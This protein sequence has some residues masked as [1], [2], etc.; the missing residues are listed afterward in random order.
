MTEVTFHLPHPIESHRLAVAENIRKI[1]E[2]IAAD[3]KSRTPVGPSRGKRRGEPHMIDCYHVTQGRDPAT[4]IITNDAPHAPA[5]EFGM[6][7]RPAQA[8]LGQAVAAARTRLL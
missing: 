8:P 4:Y 2:D 5:V 6:A 3:A 1:A 7:G